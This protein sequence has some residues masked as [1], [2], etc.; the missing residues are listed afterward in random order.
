MQHL[1]QLIQSMS[2]KHV[3]EIS[4]MVSVQDDVFVVMELCACTLD[5]HLQQVHSQA[6][7]MCPADVLTVLYSLAVGLV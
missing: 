6:Q 7:A 5:D 1:F 3:I 2:C 4:D